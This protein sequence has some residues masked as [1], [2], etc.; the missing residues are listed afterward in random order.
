[1]TAPLEDSDMPLPGLDLPVRTDH[2]VLAA[3]LADL[4]ARMAPEEPHDSASQPVV[5]QYEDA[6]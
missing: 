4:R 5:A 3:I 1:M 6:P 2:P